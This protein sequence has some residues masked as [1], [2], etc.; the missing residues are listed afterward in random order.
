MI[1]LF[2]WARATWTAGIS[3]P[4]LYL[5]GRVAAELAPSTILNPIDRLVVALRSFEFVEV[6][7]G[8]GRVRG[9]GSERRGEGMEESE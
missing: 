9:R 8:V 3:G 6:G 5:S 4:G 1:G 7:V 2:V